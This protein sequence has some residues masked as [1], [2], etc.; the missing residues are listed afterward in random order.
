MTICFIRFLYKNIYLGN[1][2]HMIFT[3]WPHI[4]PMPNEEIGGFLQFFWT[5][6]KG[7]SIVETLNLLFPGLRILDL[8]LGPISFMG[9][10]YFDPI[11]PKRYYDTHTILMKKNI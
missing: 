10:P 2:F 4:N 5:S 8:S 1:I 6:L 7:L 11:D 9:H 3:P